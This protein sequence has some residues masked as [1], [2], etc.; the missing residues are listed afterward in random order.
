M[1]SGIKRYL[2]LNLAF[3]VLL[4]LV[5][6]YEYVYLKHAITLPKGSL[7][8]EFAGVEHDILILFNLSAWLLLPFLVLYYISKHYCPVKIENN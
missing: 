4:V 8:L 7:K 3:F 6:V 2:T 5:R 1:V